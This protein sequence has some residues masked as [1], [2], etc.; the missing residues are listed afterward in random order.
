M[1]RKKLVGSGVFDD[2][3]GKKPITMLPD[4]NVVG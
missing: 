3:K 2:Y 1:N 4:R